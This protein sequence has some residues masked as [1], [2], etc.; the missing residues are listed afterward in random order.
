MRFPIQ[1]TAKRRTREH[2]VSRQRRR[3]VEERLAGGLVGG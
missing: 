2:R 3:I 1:I